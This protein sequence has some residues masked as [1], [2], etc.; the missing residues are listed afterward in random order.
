MVRKRTQLPFSINGDPTEEQ[1]KYIIMEP[2]FRK[3]KDLK[4]LIKIRE[5]LRKNGKTLVMTSGCFDLGHWGH[6]VFLSAAK[7]YG[8]YLVV[9]TNSDESITRTKGKNRPL[10]ELMF[11]LKSLSSLEPVDYILVYDNNSPIEELKALQPDVYLKGSDY[12]PDTINQEEKKIVE[13]YG[14]RVVITPKTSID[15]T[16]NI[17]NRLANY[18]YEFYN[19]DTGKFDLKL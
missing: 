10:G 4:Q 16:T 14:G 5:K 13:A 8:D 9:A 12:T 15:S 17:V 19:K 11:R 18:F 3:L 7:A 2:T 1:L 6:C